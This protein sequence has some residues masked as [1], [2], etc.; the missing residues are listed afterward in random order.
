MDGGDRHRHYLGGF[1]FPTSWYEIL[2]SGIRLGT[3]RFWFINS[4]I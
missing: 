1:S 4:P 3:H 2:V